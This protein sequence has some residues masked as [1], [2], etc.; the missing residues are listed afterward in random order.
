[1]LTMLFTAWIVSTIV[2]GATAKARSRIIERFILMGKVRISVFCFSLLGC[3]WLVFSICFGALMLF[4][5][6]FFTCTYRWV[7]NF[8]SFIIIMRTHLLVLL[9]CTLH[10]PCHVPCLGSFSFLLSIDF[11][12]FLKF[13]STLIHAPL[14]CINSFACVRR[15]SVIWTTST[16]WWKWSHRW[17]RP[18]C[19]A[20]RRAGR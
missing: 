6:L 13:I 8:S 5:F 14:I 18:P 11:Y 1:M 9:I 12:V 2:S 10:S 16:V 4:F 20:S 19:R 15:H 7:N 3:W 17:I